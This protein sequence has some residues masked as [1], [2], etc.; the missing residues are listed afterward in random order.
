M[1]TVEGIISSIFIFFF[2][3]IITAIIIFGSSIFSESP[4]NL[5]TISNQ[6]NNSVNYSSLSEYLEYCQSDSYKGLCY[7]IPYDNIEK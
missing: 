4:C 3:G 7:V 5:E 2:L 1:S 6:I